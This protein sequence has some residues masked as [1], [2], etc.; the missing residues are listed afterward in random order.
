MEIDPAA[1]E[2]SDI[3]LGELLGEV[4]EDS[5]WEAEMRHVRI[6]TRMEEPVVVRGD[7]EILR[8]AVENI[9]RNALR[10]APEGSVVELGLE[11]EGNSV[12]IRVRDQGPG[13]S[14]ENLD[15]I[16]KPFFREDSSRNSATGGL[17]LGLAIASR[18]VNLHHGR[19]HAQN[20]NPGLLIDIELPV[21]A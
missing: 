7:H 17:G 13:V 9:V 11:R 4:A 5:A 10:H 12:H 8:R 14:E 18:A 20:V 15:Q 21:A 1:R 2:M 6:V 19:L 3:S 16:F